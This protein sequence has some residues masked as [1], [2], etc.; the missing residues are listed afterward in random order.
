MAV[1]F[2]G[3]VYLVLP[4]ISQPSLI[5]FVLMTVSGI[6]WGSYTLLGQR[7]ENPLLDT[8]ANF[9]Y[10]WPLLLLTVI[11]ALTQFELTA[12]GVVLAALSGGLASGVGYAIWYK[13][14]RGLSATQAAVSQ[15]L[16]PVLAAV[17]G[18]VFVG[19]ALQMRLVISGSCILGGIGLVFWAK[20]R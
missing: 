18:V 19:E 3:F 15:L 17:G 14:L 6:A 2:S 8:Q 12:K 7:S 16:V 9:F 4:N 20:R 1:A 13:A 10:T 11:L 5:G